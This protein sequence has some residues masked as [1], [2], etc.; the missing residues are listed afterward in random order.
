VTEPLA[1]LQ[2][3][4]A[5]TATLDPEIRLGL[6]TLV[7]FAGIWAFR[8]AFPEWWEGFA[9]RP[10]GLKVRDAHD[11]AYEVLRKVW[12]QFPSL[13]S[14]AVLAYLATGKLDLAALA[15]ACASALHH[16]GKAAPIRYRGETKP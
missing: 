4:L 12:Q 5:W 11:A 13:I 8:K 2:A 14:G 3:A 1:A 10:F 7:V 15:G 16:L 9:K 6:F